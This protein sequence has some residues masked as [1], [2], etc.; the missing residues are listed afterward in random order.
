MGKYQQRDRIARLISWGHWFTFA[1]II[2]C[3]LIGLL[4]FDDNIATS[5]WLAWGY[6]GLSWLGHFAFLPFIIFI[7]LLF[8]LCILVPYS[9]FLR[10]YGSIIAAAG[11]YALLLDALF[12]RQYG[13]HL[14]TYSLSQLVTDAED[15]FAG[16]SFVLLSAA[17]FTFLALLGLQIALANLTW[18]RLHRLQRKSLAKPATAVFVVSFLSSHLLHVWADATIYTPITQQD[19]LFPLSYPTTAKSLMARHGWID[20]DTYQ[21]QRDRIV[22]T[23]RLELRYPVTSLLCAKEPRSHSTVVVAFDQ[24]SAAQ[25]DT[26]DLRLPQLQRY[27]GQLIGHPN[28]SAA[29][30]KLLYGIPDLYQDAISR[31]ERLPAYQQT[32]ADFGTQPGLFHTRNWSVAD[33]PDQLQSDLTYWTEAQFIQQSFNVVLASQ[34][35]LETVLANLQSLLRQPNLTVLITGLSPDQNSQQPG[36]GSIK[37]QLNVPLWHAGLPTPQ[38]EFAKLDDLLVTSLEQY[39]SCAE[40]FRSFSTGQSLAV[41]DADYPRVQSI[42]PYIYIFEGEQTTVLDHNGDLVVYDGNGELLPGAT[43]STSTLVRSLNELQWFSLGERMRR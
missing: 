1:N 26:I 23:E 34:S 32:L 4:Y 24:L 7:L 37:D 31:A 25:R 35:D 12:F 10:G 29:A 40:G 3:L 41:S 5:S 38:R 9:R 21:S 36:N 17:I 20:V 6:L 18:K 2:L 14:N 30:F 27:Q 11:L 39:I 42:K 22:D 43:P 8:P 33:T 16:G 28:Q 15:W 13:F 19:D